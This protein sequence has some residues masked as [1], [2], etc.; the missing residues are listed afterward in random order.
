MYIRTYTR[1]RGCLKQ[2]RKAVTGSTLAYTPHAPDG[3]HTQAHRSQP[4]RAV[5]PRSDTVDRQ[6]WR[7]HYMV[8]VSVTSAESSVSKLHRQSAL[9]SN[10]L[11]TWRKLNKPLQDAD[12]I[13][14]HRA[15]LLVRNL[16]FT[17]H[18]PMKSNRLL[19]CYKQQSIPDSMYNAGLDIGTNYLPTC[20]TNART[21]IHMSSCF[22]V[23]D[24]QIPCYTDWLSF[25]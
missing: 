2:K 9:L 14:V 19:L 4:R 3:Q 23:A 16:P 12:V 5:V 25:T 13:D 17:R 20:T 21:L 7:V 6:R 8:T 18:I 22:H 15:R 10:V 24:E 11:T 1:V